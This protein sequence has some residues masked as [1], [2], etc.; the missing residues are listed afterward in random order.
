[1]RR[2]SELI[3]RL[4]PL[5]HEARL[6]LLVQDSPSRLV[7]ALVRHRYFALAGALNVPGNFLI[8]GGGGIA[9]IAGVSKLY[10][11]TGFVLT[12][13]IAVAPVPLAVYLFGPEFLLG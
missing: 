5:D 7:P 1:M 10:S 9:L 2:T 12:I 13:A 4:D 6:K 8:G 11:V 3:R